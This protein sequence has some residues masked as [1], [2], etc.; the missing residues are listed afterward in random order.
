VKE[1]DSYRFPNYKTSLG[2]VSWQLR[3]SEENST[4]HNLDCLHK[5]YAHD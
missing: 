3:Q 2:S 5:M 1:R 4:K